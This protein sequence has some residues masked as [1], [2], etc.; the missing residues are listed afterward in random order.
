MHKESMLEESIDVD[1][2]ESYKLD[3][4]REILLRTFFSPLG[5]NTIVWIR[6]FDI[7]C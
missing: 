4:K 6:I 2:T 1:V 3:L 7:P 5:K